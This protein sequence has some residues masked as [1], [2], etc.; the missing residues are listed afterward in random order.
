MD[1]CYVEFQG[2]STMF[3]KITPVFEAYFAT[4]V[5]GRIVEVKPHLGKNARG[6][7]RVT[8]K[9]ELLDAAHNIDVFSKHLEAELKGTGI[10]VQEIDTFAASSLWNIL[11]E[12][13]GFA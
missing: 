13:F 3:A 5:P 9:F 6:D 12:L 4:K 10:R 1:L 2:P 7:K 11:R 8:F